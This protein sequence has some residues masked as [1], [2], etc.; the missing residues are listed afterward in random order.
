MLGNGLSTS[1]S[2]LPAGETFPLVT[3]A[4]NVRLQ[5]RSRSAARCCCLC[6]R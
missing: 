5:A 2:T 3:I 6:S 4:D 1:P